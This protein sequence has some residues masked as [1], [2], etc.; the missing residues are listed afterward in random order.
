MA[1][2]T[3]DALAALRMLNEAIAGKPDVVPE[4]FLTSTQWA[5]LWSTQMSST[6]RKLKA[7][8]D[9]GLFEV[10][11]F[12]VMGEGQNG[13]ITPVPHYRFLGSQNAKGKAK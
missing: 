7:G 10:R 6:W 3:V 8:V 2:S 12:R 1:I 13:K 5:K 9:A 4:D 11:R